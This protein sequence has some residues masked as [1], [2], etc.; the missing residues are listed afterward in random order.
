MAGKFFITLIV[1]M[2]VC[3]VV[4]QRFVTDKL[5]NCT[6][7]VPLGFLHPGKWVHNAVVVQEVIVP[8][9]MSE[10]DTLKEGWSMSRLWWL[11]YSFLVVSLAV[12][13][14]LAWIRWIPRRQT[15]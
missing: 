5:Y 11:W 7:S 14:G 3:T 8:R 2:V 4:W 6:D 13:M 1:M 10:P 15:E 12:S 9:S